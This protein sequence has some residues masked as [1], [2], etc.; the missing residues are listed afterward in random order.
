VLNQA[1]EIGEVGGVRAAR[2]PGFDGLRGLAATAVLVLHA[3]VLHLS[4]HVGAQEVVAQL[5][6][7]VQVFFVISGFVIARPFVAAVL[8]GRPL[9]N[10]R[11]YALRRFLRIFP[12]Y[13]LALVCARLFFDAPLSG[14]K[15]WL[16]HL[17]LL[18]TYSSYQLNRGISIAWTLSVEVAFYVLLP[19]VFLAIARMTHALGPRRALVG[20][21]GGLF[22]ASIVA[23]QWT[24]ASGRVLPTFWL[25]FQ[26]PVFA[27][28]MLMCAAAEIVA[29]EARRRDRLDWIGALLPLWWAGAAVCLLLAARWYGSTV[30]FR[31]QHQ[32]G[33]EVLYGIMAVFAVLPVAFGF[34][35]S[36]VG[37]RMLT[38]RPVASIGAISYGIYLWHHQLGDWIAQHAFGVSAYD[39]ASVA[40]LVA[41]TA[42]SLAA[43]AAVASVSWFG[44][45]RP[46]QQRSRRW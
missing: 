42:L 32:F 34:E 46:L 40:V 39:S 27:L 36:G 33:Q 30:I 45:E 4:R 38:S 12:A 2:L 37:G 20:G 6:S 19:I 18:Q 25:P 31:A 44:L 35:R 24:A 11:R 9:P 15:D 28:G 21:L 41:L 10:I 43:A 3:S 8:D 26:L 22:V 13:W 17:L 7:G 16:T 1:G 14:W 5:Q 23:L 29:R